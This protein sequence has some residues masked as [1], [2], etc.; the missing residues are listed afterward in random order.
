MFELKSILSHL[1]VLIEFNLLTPKEPA[2]VPYT[3]LSVLPGP[4]LL[5][6]PKIIDK[7]KGKIIEEGGFDHG[8]KYNIADYRLGLITIKSLTTVA[9]KHPEPVKGEEMPNDGGLNEALFTLFTEIV[10]EAG[11]PE[12]MR[13]AIDIPLVVEDG[14]SA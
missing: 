4:V 9:L 13:S 14:E 2:K 12:N 10:E 3:P 6:I 5:C 11:R 7:F 8:K 1:R